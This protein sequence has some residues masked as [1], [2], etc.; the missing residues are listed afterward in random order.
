MPT[1]D[2]TQPFPEPLTPGEF[3]RAWVDS[4]YHN[5]R[6]T[7][8]RLTRAGQLQSQAAAIEADAQAQMLVMLEQ[9][10]DPVR[11]VGMTPAGWLGQ[12][13]LAAREIL[14]A[15]LV[16]PAPMEDETSPADQ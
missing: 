3:G 14:M 7:Y 5:D 11:P 12:R 10:D 4:L 15:D 1:Y 8:D 16:I 13:R 6:P 2:P 9:T